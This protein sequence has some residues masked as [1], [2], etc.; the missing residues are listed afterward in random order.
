M[1]LLKKLAEDES[2]ATTVE[3]VAMAFGTS[4][5]I[6]ILAQGMASVKTILSRANESF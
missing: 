2:G 6:L 4:L 5:A 1:H 3:Y